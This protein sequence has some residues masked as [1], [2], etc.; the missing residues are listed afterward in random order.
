MRLLPSE[1]ADS[2]NVPAASKAMIRCFRA[3]KARQPMMASWVRR[4]LRPALHLGTE[5]AIVTTAVSAA[6]V[7]AALQLEV[8]P[9]CF[10][11]A[12][13]TSLMRIFRCVKPLQLLCPACP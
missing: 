7:V 9:E 6:E 10:F 4:R 13:L 5:Q 3:P 12:G 8:H 11:I 1:D 2:M